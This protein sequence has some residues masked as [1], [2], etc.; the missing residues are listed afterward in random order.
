MAH[1][2]ARKR[3]SGIRY[4]ANVR[5]KKN[6]V[7]VHRESKTFELRAAAE[8]WARPREVALEDP[9]ALIRIL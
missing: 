5:I 2:L 7:V 9:T 8:K 3:D 6:G 1:I 4:T